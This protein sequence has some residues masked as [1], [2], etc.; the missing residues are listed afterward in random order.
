MYSNLCL[1]VITFPKSLDPNQAQ[2][3]VGH[4]LDPKLF[5]TL[6]VFLKEYFEKNDFEKKIS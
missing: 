4:D 5:D 1:F 6:M 2:Q 3:K